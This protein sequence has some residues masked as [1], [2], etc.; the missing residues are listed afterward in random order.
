MNFQLK[1]LR[2]L[3]GAI[4]LFMAERGVA[5]PTLINELGGQ[6]ISATTTKCVILIHGWNPD[7]YSNFYDLNS[8]FE[9]FNLLT[10]LKARLNGSGWGVVAYHWEDDAATGEVFDFNSSSWLRDFSQPFPPNQAS[11]NAKVDGANLATQLND[12]SPNLRKVHFIAHSAGSWAAREAMKRILQL[13]P[14][15][16]VQMTL[17]DP[18]IVDPSGVFTPDYSDNAMNDAQFFAGSERIQRLESY[19]AD[20]SPSDGWNAF[21]WGSRAWPTLKTQEPFQWRSGIDINQRVD[22]GAVLVNPPGPNNT[23]LSVH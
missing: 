16:V 3:F 18:Y 22:W 14:Y 17:L 6:P 13:N 12:L 21:P 9:W 4:A 15:V 2:I 11:V 20:D 23:R 8:G 1:T 10:S 19:Y 5:Q 7:D